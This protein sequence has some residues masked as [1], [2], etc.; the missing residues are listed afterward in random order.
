MELGGGGRVGRDGIT[1]QG[2]VG[3]D[4][5]ALAKS[6]AFWEDR[7]PTAAGALAGGA[8]DPAGSSSRWLITLFMKKSVIGSHCGN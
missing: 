5:C 6:T 7:C 1:G 4:E 3:N 2:S 8:Q